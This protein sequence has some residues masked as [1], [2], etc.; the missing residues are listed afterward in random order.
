M[1]ADGQYNPGVPGLLMGQVEEFIP[2]GPGFTAY[3][4]IPAISTCK[5][6]FPIHDIG[7]IQCIIVTEPGTCHAFGA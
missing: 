4:A 2:D 5:S 7:F 3:K 1:Q 6:R